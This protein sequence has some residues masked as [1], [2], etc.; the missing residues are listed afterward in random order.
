M[1]TAFTISQSSGKPMYLQVVEQVSERIRA[2]AWPEGAALPS[3]RDLAAQISVSVITVKTAYEELEKLGLIEK[4]QGS[5]TFVKRGAQAA[6][7]QSFSAELQTAVTEI[8]QRAHGAGVTR[9]AAKKAWD[10]AVR[11]IYGDK[12]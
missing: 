3:I 1:N 12:P 4:T 11:R 9:E 2:G 5:G 8:L 6:G 10:R 7:R